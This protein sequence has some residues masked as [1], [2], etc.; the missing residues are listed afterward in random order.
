MLSANLFTLCTLLK[1]S[2]E[3]STPIPITA[4]DVLTHARKVLSLPDA[5]VCISTPWFLPLVTALP[6]LKFTIIFTA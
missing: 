4:I 6:Y 1:C 2:V 5:A 3:A